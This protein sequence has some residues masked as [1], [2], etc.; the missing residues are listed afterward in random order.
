[1]V[2]E[3]FKIS[4]QNLS[5]GYSSKTIHSDLNL[6]AQTGE[7]ICILGKNGAGKSTL[8]RTLGNLQLPLG[9]TVKIDG[10]E[11]PSIA[12]SALARKIAIVSTE[13]IVAPNMSISELVA[14]GRHPYT[15]WL[16]HLS[17]DDHERIN[18]SIQRCNLGHLKDE[19]LNELSDGQLQKA[20]IARAL[21]QDTDIVL[22]D[23]PTAHLDL[24]N[25]AEIMKI[26]SEIKS[27]KCILVS[28]HE[29]ALAMQFSDQLWLMSSK[30]EVVTGFPEDL[31]LSGAI[32]T[33]LAGDGFDLDEVS[34]NVL[35][36]SDVKFSISLE[37]EDQA[38]YWVRQA[39]KRNGIKIDPNS[40]WKIIASSEAGKLEWKLSS[41]L[42][43]ILGK[44][45]EELVVHLRTIN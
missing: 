44:G 1:M 36:K 16:G 29:L 20:M 12:Q 22:L 3:N 34:G 5:I 33:T 7:L 8:L 21:A 42:E 11:M 25:R 30:N 37:G 28:T 9:G 23:E 19:K 45:I 2:K 13:K 18:E 24:I 17:T 10:K 6:S 31:G 14:L 4:T 35:T 27:T 26:L 40:D 41:D 43:N 39:L 38:V 15:N 32:K